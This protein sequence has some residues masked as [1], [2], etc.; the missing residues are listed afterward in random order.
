MIDSFEISFEISRAVACSLLIIAQTVYVASEIPLGRHGEA[1]KYLFR[2]RGNEQLFSRSNFSLWSLATHR[3]QARQM[4]RH[5]EPDAVQIELL[6][7]LDRGRPD[8]R[9]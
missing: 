4:L 9:I 2:L 3:L 5:E 8:L 1:I 7:L 6:G